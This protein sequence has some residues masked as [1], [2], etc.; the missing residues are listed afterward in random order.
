MVLTSQRPE[1]IDWQVSSREEEGL[2]ECEYT[3]QGR[4]TRNTYTHLS[5]IA[6]V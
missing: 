5:V 6:E 2:T 4:I 1:V 3:L